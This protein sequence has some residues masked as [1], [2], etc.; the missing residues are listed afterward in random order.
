LI[1]LNNLYGLPKHRINA[2]FAYFVDENDKVMTENFAERF[3]DHRRVAQAFTAPT[4]LRVP[5]LIRVLCE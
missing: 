1:A 3:V 4:K 2:K 5:H